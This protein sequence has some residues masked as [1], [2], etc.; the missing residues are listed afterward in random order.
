MEFEHCMSGRDCRNGWVCT[1]S[2]NWYLGTSPK[3][4]LSF[5]SLHSC[6]ARLASQYSFYSFLSWKSSIS[7]LI[8]LYWLF[9][10]DQNY[11]GIHVQ[12]ILLSEFYLITLCK[13]FFLL[14]FTPLQ[15]LLKKNSRWHSFILYISLHL[16]M[17]TPSPKLIFP[18]SW[19]V[20]KMLNSV[21]LLKMH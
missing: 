12:G 15:R 10:D 8:I 14:F 6:I 19:D 13:T 16:D 1:F 7:A 18:M 17:I 2:W 20:Y 3:I 9:I 4:F 21:A 11:A 5:Y